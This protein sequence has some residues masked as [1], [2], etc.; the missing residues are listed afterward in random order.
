MQEVELLAL[1]YALDNQHQKAASWN[2]F[3]RARHRQVTHD[4]PG[5]TIHV[6]VCYWATPP[7]S[8]AQCARDGERKEQ[9]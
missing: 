6:A 5:R 4:P 9:F 3:G 7:E 2:L 8:M 1:F